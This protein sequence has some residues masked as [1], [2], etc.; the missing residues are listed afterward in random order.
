MAVT[1]FLM[2][3]PAGKPVLLKCCTVSGVVVG[4]ESFLYLNFQNY[5]GGI[6]KISKPSKGLKG[7]SSCDVRYILSTWGHGFPRNKT[8]NLIRLS[9]SPKQMSPMTNKAT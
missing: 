3:A 8:K 7:V 6:L 5:T 1:D 9:L 2:G 4:I